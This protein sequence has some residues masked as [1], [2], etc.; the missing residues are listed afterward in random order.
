[1]LLAAEQTYRKA[2]ETLDFLGISISR[3]TIHRDVQVAGAHL[4]KRDEETALDHTGKRVV[5]LLIM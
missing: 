1:V 4:K 5:P 3:E 2:A